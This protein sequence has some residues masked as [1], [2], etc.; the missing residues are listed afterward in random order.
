MRQRCH[1]P[2]NEHYSQYGGRGITVCDKWE[3]YETFLLDMGD[4]PPGYSIERVDVNKNYCPENCKWAS[5]LEQQANRRN[6]IKVNFQNKTQTIS[7]WARELGICPATI[8]YRLKQGYSV[9]EAL[10]PSNCA[11]TAQN[12]KN[13]AQLYTFKGKSLSVS[14]WA[15]KFNLSKN[16]LWNRVKQG[17]DFRDAIEVAP[18]AKRIGDVRILL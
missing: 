7:E 14:E 1:N 10:N 16:T 8:G 12:N 5:D 11:R 18:G 3:R 17:W 13:R 2:N 15:K 4:P 6:N 9:A